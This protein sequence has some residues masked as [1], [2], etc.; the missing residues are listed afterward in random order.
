[1][2]TRIHCPEILCHAGAVRD[3]SAE[4]DLSGLDLPLAVVEGPV[5]LDAAL[6]GVLEG[7][8]VAGSVAAD[9]RLRCARCLY[10]EVRPVET[11][12][13]ELFSADPELEEDDEV[14]PAEA[15][16]IDV[17][18]LLVDAVVLA[19]PESPV[20]CEVTPE[21]CPRF[22]ELVAAGKV[23]TTVG[24]IDPRWAALSGLLDET[25][26]ET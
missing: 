26:K 5:R 2:N 4:F 25:D 24:D 20:L 7:L 6:E 3:V 10:E 22:R 9:V 18:Q 11:T 15:D 12:V 13:M 19:V 17:E 1:M 21:E 23:Q 14:Y 8:V 16:S